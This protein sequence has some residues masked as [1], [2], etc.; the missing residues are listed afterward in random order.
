MTRPSPFFLFL[1][2]LVL[3]FLFPLEAEPSHP[4]T[5]S[6]LIDLNAYPLYVRPGFDQ[7]MVGTRPALE[8]GS[9]LVYG[10]AKNGER[11]LTLIDL[12]NA[13]RR[14]FLDVQDHRAVEYTYVIPFSLTQEEITPSTSRMDPIPG[15]ELGALGD[16]WEIYLNGKLLRSEVYL[17]YRGQIIHH[18]IARH[19]FF[20]IDRELLKSAENLLVFRIIGDPT[21]AATG[22]FVSQP[23]KITDYASIEAENN[24][25]WRITLYGIY[26]FV[27]LYYLFIFFLR[28]QDRYNLFYGLFSLILGFYLFLRTYFVYTLFLDTALSSK[29]EYATVL[30]TIPLM[31]AF[32][33]TLSINRV[34]IVTFIFGLFYAFLAVLQF[35]FSLSFSLDIITLWQRSSLFLILY[36]YLYSVLW[37]FF[38]SGYRRWKR[39]ENS[40]IPRS[41]LKEWASSLLSTPLGNTLLGMTLLFVTALYDVLDSWLFHTELVLSQYGL[42][43]FIIGTAGIL[44]NRYNFVFKQL[45]V[46]NIN[47]ERRIDDLARTKEHLEKSEAT[48]RSRFEGR[49]EALV[50][51]DSDFT[52]RD[53]NPAAVEFFNLEAWRADIQNGRG[54]DLGALLF[55]NEQEMGPLAARLAQITEELR[56][57][58]TPLEGPVLVKGP[59]GE[60]RPCTFRLELLRS[61]DKGEILL[62]AIPDTGGEAPLAVVEGRVRYD[63]ENTLAAADWT[64]QGASENLRAYLSLESIYRVRKSLRELIVN[65]IEHGNLEITWQEKLRALRGG[66]YLELIQQKKKLPE[67]RNRRVSLEYSITPQRAV[68]TITDQGK[69]FVHEKYVQRARKVGENGALETLGPGQGIP[70]ALR[71]FDRLEYNDTGNQVTVEKRFG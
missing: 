68:F 35:F 18:R 41:L 22:F 2:A 63:I 19:I 47:L 28:P 11:V 58:H 37:E 4:R 3:A 43:V 51:L 26:V 61:N 42:F 14:S 5:G 69:G 10:P 64:A 40:M 62:T 57:S 55:E 33:E 44:S 71:T 46:A 60:S 32:V 52:V 36:I 45:S 21:N 1:G 24:A 23:Y 56:T 9:W 50:I 39:Q 16:N 30:L 59:R 29:L 67:F 13:P 7:S 38:S 54:P 8:D 53:C 70:L 49:R 66:R 27:G 25:V 48:Y 17:D 6:F 15:I 34:R 20:P 12:P 65:A 31:G